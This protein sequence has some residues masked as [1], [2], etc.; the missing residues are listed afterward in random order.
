MDKPKKKIR[1][2]EKKLMNALIDHQDSDQR[3]R[4]VKR[5]IYGEAKQINKS[6]N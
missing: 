1:I 5:L 4:Y 6:K 2:L 3:K